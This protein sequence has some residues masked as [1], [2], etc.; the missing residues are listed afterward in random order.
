MLFYCTFIIHTDDTYRY[1]IWFE[2][3]KSHVRISYIEKLS[4]LLKL[5]DIFEFETN[6]LKEPNAGKIVFPEQI[7][8]CRLP[9]SVKE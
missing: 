4:H 9:N 2:K 7:L 8:D 6:G 1:K 3:I 5:K